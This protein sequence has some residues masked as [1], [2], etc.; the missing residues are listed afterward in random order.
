MDD[1]AQNDFMSRISLPQ[2]QVLA[3]E[4]DFRRETKGGKGPEAAQTAFGFGRLFDP[5][6][7]Q[8]ADGQPSAS[9]GPGAGSRGPNTSGFVRLATFPSSV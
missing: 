7:R 1:Y 5:L 8:K 6:E 4:A 3:G 9:A 2:R